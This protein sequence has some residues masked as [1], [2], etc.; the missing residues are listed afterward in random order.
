MVARGQTGGVAG[1]VV[2][3]PLTGRVL[4]LDEVPDPVFAERMV[5]PGL[6]VL[7]AVEDG[8]VVTAT[9]PC[10][11]R[12]ASIL[13]HAFVVEVEDGRA[14]LVHLGIDTVGLGGAGFLLRARA[15]DLVAAGDPVVD[16]TPRDVVGAGLSAVCPVVALQ[17]LEGSV[18][19]ERPGGASVSAGDPLLTWSR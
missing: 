9:A 16:W 10:A 12:V 1:L 3:S 14:V 18:R 11:G 6:A 7:P 13:P 5:G 19:P 4:A 2:A 8:R 15:G 17:A